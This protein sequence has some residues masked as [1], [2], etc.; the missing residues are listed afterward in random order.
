MSCSRIYANAKGDGPDH[1]GPVRC[2]ALHPGQLPIPTL[3]LYLCENVVVT[4][5]EAYGPLH[6]KMGITGDALDPNVCAFARGGCV[7][8]CGWEC[9]GQAGGKGGIFC[10]QPASRYSGGVLQAA[11]HKAEVCLDVRPAPQPPPRRESQRQRRAGVRARC[12]RISRFA[13]RAR[14]IMRLR[15]LLAPRGKLYLISVLNTVYM[16]FL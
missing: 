4:Y 9:L 1:A 13:E 12:A 11:R 3:V 2:Y 7:A 16:A 8:A 10:S 15:Q 14:W 5:E 6:Q